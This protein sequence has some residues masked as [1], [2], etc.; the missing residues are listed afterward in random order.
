[1]HDRY[2]AVV[3]AR[4]C[5]WRRHRDQLVEIAPL[6]CLL[7]PPRAAVATAGEVQQHFRQAADRFALADAHLVRV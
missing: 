3:S 1:M 2:P 6:T 4:Q 7:R 5:G